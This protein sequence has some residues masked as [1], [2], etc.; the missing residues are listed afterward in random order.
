MTAIRT[1]KANIG[2]TIAR[3]IPARNDRPK[4]ALYVRCSTIEQDTNNQI[5]QLRDFCAGRNYEVVD[6]FSEND[7]AWKNGHQQELKRLMNTIKTGQKHYDI[8]VTWAL[9]RLSREGISALMNILN[10]FNGYGVKLL[11]FKEL[12]M[13]EI[14]SEFQ[15]LFIAWMGF[16]AK[17]ESDRRSARIRAG[18]QRKIETEG[19]KPGRKPGAKDR[20]PRKKTGYLMRYASP[21]TRAKYG[22]II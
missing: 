18:I 5:V 12:P 22:Q 15:P 11:S 7:T 17:W 1:I 14:P 8:V 6:I 9:D 13:T 20:T 2:S 4:V 16:M 19:Y 10:T 21:R 3:M